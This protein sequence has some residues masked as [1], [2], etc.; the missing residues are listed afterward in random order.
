M[1]PAQNR[2]RI[3]HLRAVNAPMPS[4]CENDAHKSRRQRASARRARRRAATRTGRFAEPRG[5][6]GRGEVLA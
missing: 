6:L 2:T 1:T 5:Q 4:W 3:N